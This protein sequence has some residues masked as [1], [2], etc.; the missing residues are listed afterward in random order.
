MDRLDTWAIFAAVAEHGSFAGAARALGRSPAAVTRAVAGLESRLASRLFNR[1]T[2]A[3]ALTDVGA[4][5]LDTCRR[6]LADFAEL[7]A[8]ASGE[9]QQPRGV[10]NV[11]APVM[12]GRLHVL[13]IV[14]QFLANW[15]DVDTRLLFL[16]RVVSLIDEGLDV[17]VRLGHL[18]DSSLRAILAGHVRRCVYASPDYL[19]HFG[20]PQ[21]P[22]DL[23]R[24]R[25]IACTGVT[26]IP[27]RWTFEHGERRHAV[28]VRPRVIVNTT[29]AA[30]DAAL[31]ALG[32]VCML[33]YQADA[34]VVAGRLKR[35]LVTN[36]PP[37]LPI[38]IVHPAGRHLSAKVRL[39]IDCATAA[40]RARFGGEGSH[41]GNDRP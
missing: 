39:F 19:A 36:E 3:V 17:G 38:H 10:L 8:T 40:L 22:Q 37:P 29:D 27:E 12:F 5:Y 18:P 14:Q 2:R 31:A 41:V 34:H 15:P 24:H 11:T 9:R 1:T 21:T 7:E 25:C 6:V 20:E 4:R 35:I 32:I 33:S 13:P 16:D 23:S 26:P 30:I 28:A